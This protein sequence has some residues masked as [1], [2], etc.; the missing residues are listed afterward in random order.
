[1]PGGPAFAPSFARA[2][3]PTLTHERSDLVGAL[4]ALGALAAMPLET[5]SDVVRA[6]RQLADTGLRDLPM[7]GTGATATR[8]RALSEIAAVDLSL[9]RLVEGHLDARAILAEAARSPRDGLY[10]VWAAEPSDAQLRAIRTGPHWRLHGR[11]R[12]ASGARGLARALITAHAD[13]GARL[14]DVALDLPGVHPLDGTWPAIG[15]ARTD[16]LE[17]DFD[18]VELDDDAAIGAP[19][20]YLARPGFWHGAIGV[21]ACWYG[22]ALGAARMLRAYLGDH[23]PDPH[24]LA[25]LGAVAAACHAMQLALDDAARE[26]DRDPRASARTR[27]LVVRAVVE[28]GCQDVLARAGRASGTSPLAFDR[29]HARRAADLIVYL[30]Q[31]HAERDLAELGRANLAGGS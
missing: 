15:M 5:T 13:D 2:A 24:Q 25:H 4:G 20:F 17:V 12:Y 7:P 14:F 31:H 1:M 10:G 23:E 16:S 19:G 11:K 9:V 22:G 3:R 29:R 6:T 18:G 30:R 26:I 28:Q 8:L 21:A 27:A